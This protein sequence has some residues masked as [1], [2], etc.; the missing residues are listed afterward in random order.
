MPEKRDFPQRSWSVT[1]CFFPT[2]YYFKI[3]MK[4][5][6]LTHEGKIFPYYKNKS[7]FCRF[8]PHFLV[9][10][11][12]KWICGTLM[13]TWKWNGNNYVLHIILLHEVPIGTRLVCL[14]NWEEILKVLFKA[15]PLL[16]VWQFSIHLIPLDLLG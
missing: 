14:G 2:H 3:K 13:F 6:E 4:V 16:Q 5:A 9:V 10:R 1:L 15:T 7:F 11:K 8:F 12:F